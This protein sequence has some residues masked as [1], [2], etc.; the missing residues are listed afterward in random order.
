[1]FTTFIIITTVLVIAVVIFAGVKLNL[2]THLHD[3]NKTA[4]HITHLELKAN[5]IN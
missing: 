5:Q 4:Y 2:L 1:M 3:T